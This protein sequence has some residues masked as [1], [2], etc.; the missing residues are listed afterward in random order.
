MAPR[1][2]VAYGTRSLQPQNQMNRP[3]LLK[4]TIYDNADEA[5]V[6]TGAYTPARRGARDAFGVPLEPDDDGTIEITEAVCPANG[7]ARCLS[8]KETAKAY[9]ALWAAAAEDAA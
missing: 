7:T 8:A 2:G 4:A 6:I 5:I 9:E 3:I 1:S